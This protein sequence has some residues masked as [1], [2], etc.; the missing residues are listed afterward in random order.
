MKTFPAVQGRKTGVLERHHGIL[1]GVPHR[2][3]LILIRLS[4]HGD[5]TPLMGNSRCFTEPIVADLFK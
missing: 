1:R 2:N 3:T 4:H 5:R